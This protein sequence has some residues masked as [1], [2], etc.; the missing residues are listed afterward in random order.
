M[1]PT[2]HRIRQTR[3]RNTPL[4]ED[5][6]VVIQ[7]L[8]SSDSED[9]PLYKLIPRTSLPATSSPESSNIRPKQ[10]MFILL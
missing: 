2:T 3:A 9:G 6:D 4:P 5:E 8:S 10:C 1:A 7:V